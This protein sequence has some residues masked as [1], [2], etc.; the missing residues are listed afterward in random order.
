MKK[1]CF[2]KNLL[3]QTELT[4]CFLRRHPSEQ[5]SE[6]LSL[7]QNGSEQNFKCLLILFQG[8]EFRVVF[9]STVWF[10]RNSE[11][12]LLIFSIV[13]NSNHFYRLQNGSEWNSESFLFCGTA[14]TNQLFRLFRLPR[15]NFFVGNC[16]P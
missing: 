16:Q 15:N 9:S 4:A 2:T 14:E 11:R 13:Q 5:N 3:Q 6:L 7:P 12:L 8:T 10:R 1:I